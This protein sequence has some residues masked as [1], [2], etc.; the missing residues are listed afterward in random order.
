MQDIRQKNQEMSLHAQSMNLVS[1][2]NEQLSDLA[3][4][5]EQ[6]L[7]PTWMRVMMRLEL[8]AVLF[9]NKNLNALVIHVR[10]WIDSEILISAYYI[11]FFFYSWKTMFLCMEIQGFIWKTIS[12]NDAMFLM[13]AFCNTC[14]DFHMEK[15]ELYMGF[16]APS[17]NF[18]KSNDPKWLRLDSK[19]EPL[20]S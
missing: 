19:P 1:N 10:R 15:T 7:P 12:S 18:G 17:E 4:F 13:R 6:S 16:K 9:L 20:S 3:C 5:P 8:K 11:R 14:N 2:L